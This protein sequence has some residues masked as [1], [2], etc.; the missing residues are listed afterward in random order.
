MS[1]QVNNQGNGHFLKFLEDMN[2]DKSKSVNKN[3]YSSN[4]KLDDPSFSQN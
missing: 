1:N 2:T 4:L 3:I